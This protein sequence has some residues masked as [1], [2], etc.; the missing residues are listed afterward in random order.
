MTSFRDTKLCNSP[1]GNYLL[2]TIKQPTKIQNLLTKT[3]FE[4]KVEPVTEAEVTVM[5]M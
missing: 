4:L 2:I 1:N 3:T 5:C